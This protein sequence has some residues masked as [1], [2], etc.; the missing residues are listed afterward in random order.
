ME[1]INSIADLDEAIWLLEIKQSRDGL[2]MKEQFRDTVESLKPVN[3]IKNAF[4][5][6]STPAFKGN[7][8]DIAISMAAGYVSKKVVIG[9]THNPIKQL[10][11]NLIQMRVT[12]VVSK[13]T[14]GIKSTA[15]N[16]LSSLFNKKK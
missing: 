16:L 13:N 14:D 4:K 15:V 8:L 1:K 11:G 9:G 7:L 5:E 2:L 3:L 6:L 10:F 12:S